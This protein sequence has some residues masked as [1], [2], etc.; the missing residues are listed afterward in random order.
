VW[1]VLAL[2]LSLGAM[3]GLGDLPSVF[4]ATTWHA[5]E[6]IFGFAGAA[7]AGYALTLIP[8]WT[9][10]FPLQGWPL[11]MLAGLWAAGRL[12]VTGSAVLGAGPALLVDLALP[13]LV[14]AASAREVVTG[15][16]WR[17]LPVLGALSLLLTG[18][19]L[20]HLA[21]LGLAA[22]ADLGIRLGLATLLGL[23]A[24][25]GGRLLPSF[26][27][28][29][30]ARSGEA[31][32]PAPASAIDRVALALV[33]AA[34]VAWSLAPGSIMTPPLALAAGIATFFRQGRWRPHR[35]GREAILVA[36]H[37]GY[38][39]L[40]LGLVLLGAAPITDRLPASAALH[41]LGAG[42]VG[43]MIL[44]VMCRTSL[45][46]TGRPPVGDTGTAIA[47]LA[48]TLAAALRVTAELVPAFYPS[49]LFAA[50]ASWIVGFSLFVV[51][52]API[53][54][55]ARSSTR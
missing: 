29:R 27:R 52:Y 30:L 35:I 48:L 16:N 33:V 15:R 6:M 47:S 25:I 12:A 37:L 9:G 36:L 19:T 40:A 10:R 2:A 54:A 49:L 5:H 31:V 24:L 14:L 17:N 20:M 44:A 26:T 32:F 53:L 39:W 51:I 8:N 55:A 34:L 50:G 7:V 1:A 41:A 43:T 4:D 45:A 18:N 21:A 13:A 42:A 22:T 38:A 23:I 3:T 46:H 11:A 28:N